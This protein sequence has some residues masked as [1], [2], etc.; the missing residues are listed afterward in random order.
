MKVLVTGSEGYIGTLL[1]PMLTA[2]GHQVTRLDSRLFKACAFGHLDCSG[3][4]VNMDIRDVA[5]ADLAGYDAVIH[6]A[7]LS[8][9]PLSDLSPDLTMQINH[10]AAVEL[11]RLARDAGVARFVFSSTCSVYGF[12]GD[13]YITESSPL[14]PLTAY[15][16]SKVLAER[17]IDEL[18]GGGFTTVSLRHGT[19]YGYSPMIRFDLVVNNLVAWG[20]TTGRI[21]LKS[22]GSAWRPLVHVADICRSFV[23]AL[24]ADAE[25]VDGEVF[26]IGRTEDNIRIRDLGH[27]IAE[28][29]PGCVLEFADGAS[30]D[31]RSYRVDCS[32]AC[33]KLPGFAA[34]VSLDEGIREVIDMVTRSDIAGL[35]FEEDRY[36]RIAHLRHQLAAGSVGHDLRVCA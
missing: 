29:M 15:A 12:Q 27:L 17:D 30:P 8:N 6:L 13:D 34:S 28:R 16:R 32:K 26:N 35:Q 18:R 9:D 33:E 21:L 23:S 11:A 20:H 2:R 24:E 10:E 19:A 22:D 36:G 4:L 25:A 3:K 5:M 1:V 7:G 14:N 31:N